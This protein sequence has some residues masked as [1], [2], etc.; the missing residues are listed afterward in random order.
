MTPQKRKAIDDAREIE[1][2]VARWLMARG[3]LCLPVYDYSG[4]SSEKAPKLEAFASEDSLVTPD[5]L[6]VRG[7]VLRWVEVKFKT[8]ADVYRRTG[9]LDTGIS[10]YLWQ[11][12]ER[13][14]RASGAQAWLAFAHRTEGVITLNSWREMDALSPRLSNGPDP[15]GSVFW[16]LEKLR[17][18]A[19]YAD[20][21]RG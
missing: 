14:Q 8:S 17:V 6:V 12:Y 7:G 19:A 2:S 3:W 21:V 10:L 18:V 9:S 13:V 5:L 11:A 16:P 1:R 15:G 4:L 20:V